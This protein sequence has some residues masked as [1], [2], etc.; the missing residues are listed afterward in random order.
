MTDRDRTIRDAVAELAE[1]APNAP[2]F[3]AIEARSTRGRSV[4]GAIGLVTASAV[5]VVLSVS[6]VLGV[7]ISTLGLGIAAD[8]GGDESPFRYLGLLVALV[9]WGGLFIATTRVWRRRP[10]L[11][12]VLGLAGV[13]VAV[14]G[15]LLTAALS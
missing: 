6:L 12:L 8:G 5:G 2:T 9:A 1:G 4:I 10:W 14:G 11:A 15:F 7:L 13:A 3:G